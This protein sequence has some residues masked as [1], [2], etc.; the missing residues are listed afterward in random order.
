MTTSSEIAEIFDSVHDQYFDID[1]LEFDADRGEVRLP[2]YAGRESKRWLGW[3]TSRPPTE[4]LPP[5]IGILIVQDV[6]G[7]SVEDEADIG[8]YD[9]NHGSY[10]V[11]RGE[12]RIVSNVPCDIVVRGR[13][14]KVSL[15]P[16][17]YT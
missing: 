8:W 6:V 12:L 3:S 16:G 13:D 1:R 10:D 17:G 15:S 11:E 4:P 7:V 9:I 14:I 2:I 5:P